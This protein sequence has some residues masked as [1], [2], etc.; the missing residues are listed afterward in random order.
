MAVS[1]VSTRA[2]LLAFP[3]GVRFIVFREKSGGWLQP[4][5]FIR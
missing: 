4:D 1:I 5:V 2:V 3:W